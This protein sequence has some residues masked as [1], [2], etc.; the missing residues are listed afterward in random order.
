MMAK[1]RSIDIFLL[2]SLIAYFISIFLFSLIIHLIDNTYGIFWII[3]TISLILTVL[4]VFI[5]RTW[6]L[7]ICIAPSLVFFT[8]VFLFHTIMN[9]GFRFNNL[10][11]VITTY[12]WPMISYL[13]F[14]FITYKIVRRKKSSH[15]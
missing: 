14:I 15:I 9:R 4:Y 5:K 13:F 7:Y 11:Y 8:Y 3:P 2:I 1:K 12:V 10:S 6:F